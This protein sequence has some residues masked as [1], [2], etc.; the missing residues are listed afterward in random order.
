MNLCVHVQNE[1]KN[2]YCNWAP[3]LASTLLG[4]QIPR[5]YVALSNVAGLGAPGSVTAL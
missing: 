3:V 4:G 2:F 1:S 5:L